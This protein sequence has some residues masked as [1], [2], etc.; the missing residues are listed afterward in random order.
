M[1][2]DASTGLQNLW[3]IVSNPKEAFATITKKGMAFMP[4][5]LALVILGE[6]SVFF[7]E[8]NLNNFLQFVLGIA[9]FFL[10]IFLLQVFGRSFF[11]GKANYWSLFSSIAYISIISLVLTPFIIYGIRSSNNGL[12][13]VLGAI[14]TV[15]T[16]ILSI[17]AVSTA[18][19]I[20]G[21]RAFWVMLAAGIVVGLV[22]L[23]VNLSLGI[24]NLANIAG[25][26]INI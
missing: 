26:A 15:W 8:T 6:L 21:L 25:Q 17:M 24:D 14:I 19:K 7:I 4:W 13:I 9:L 20:S 3:K 1:V 5:A 16:L 12:I 18:H 2:V 11:Y 22:A 10:Q 23:V